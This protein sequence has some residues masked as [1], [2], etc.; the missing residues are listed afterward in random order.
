MSN[1]FYQA[2]Q[3]RFIKLQF[4]ISFLESAKL[5]KHK[6]SALR[7]GMG[8]MLLSMNCVRDRNCEACDFE[9]ECIVRRTLYS[10]LE[11]VPAFVTANS[12]IGYLLECENHKEFFNQGETMTFRLILFGK[13]IVYFNQFIQAF[14]LMGEQNGIGKQHARFQIMKIHST[15]GL[16]IFENGSLNMNHFIIHSLYD[17]IMFRKYEI[18]TQKKEYKIVFHTPL[19]LKYNNEYLNEFQS[20]AIINAAKRRIYML[21]CY[22]GIE[23]SCICPDETYSAPKILY[24]ECRLTG[25]SRYSFRKEQPMVLRGITGYLILP[26]LPDGLLELLL[27]GELTHI[28]KNTSFGFGQYRLLAISTN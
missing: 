8:E 17:Y 7:G 16:P 18:S 3:I 24:Q 21:S 4:T 2:M 13:A 14:R 19:T 6:I 28:G 27:A 9:Q 26:E 11:K 25:I 10:R 12:S 15:E 22:E 23:Q 5:P 20:D 1:I